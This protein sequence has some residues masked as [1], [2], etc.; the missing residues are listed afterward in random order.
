LVC[1][2]WRGVALNTTQLW[3]HIIINGK[4]PPARALVDISRAR[5]SCLLDIDIDFT[6]RPTSD[7]PA[8]AIMPEAS[9]GC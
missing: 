1:Y 9:N 5:P 2:Y 6:T 3:S 8:Y 4:F 7:P